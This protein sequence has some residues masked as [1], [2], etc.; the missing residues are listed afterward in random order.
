MN[1][2]IYLVL[3]SEI[4][5]AL[6]SL[7]DKIMLSKNYIKSPFVFIVFNGLMNILL[8]FLLPFFSFGKLGAADIFISLA[9]G[10]FLTLGVIFYYK[11]VQN[12]E[13]SRVLIMWQFTPIFVLL[14]SFLFLGD[15]LTSNYLIGFLLLLAGG[16][17]VS[18]KKMKGSFKLSRAFY[19]M[20]ASTAL[21]SVYYVSSAH[22]YKSTGFWSA[23]MWLRLASFSSVLLLL[24]PKIRK[25]FFETWKIMRRNSK[26]L[27]TSKMIIDFSA[28]IILGLAIIKGPIALISALGSAA[29]PIFIF[30]ITLFTTIFLPQ[31]IKE[32]ISRKTILIKILAIALTIIGIVFVNY[33]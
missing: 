30:L 26:F 22:I 19:C 12:E 14:F 24:V 8:V 29:A 15:I 4:M 3:L 5:W 17:A 18:Y 1:T 13:I 28:F 33:N 2:W 31:I 10:I 16:L 11:A 23:F 25:E 32:D 6:T 9:A 21:I 20:L 7:I 27:I